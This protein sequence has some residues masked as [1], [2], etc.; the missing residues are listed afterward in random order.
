MLAARVMETMADRDEIVRQMP[1]PEIHDS[2]A[3]EV[4]LLTT[5]AGRA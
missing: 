2:L 4:D 3:D 5:F 1:R